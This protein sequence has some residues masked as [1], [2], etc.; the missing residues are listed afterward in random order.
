MNLGQNI[1]NMI[2]TRRK[3]HVLFR[4]FGIGEEIDSNN[5]LTKGALQVEVNRWYPATEIKK[6]EVLEA[7]NKGEFEYYVEIKGV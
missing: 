6:F 2:K 1:V 3:T 5:Q 7:S 4:S